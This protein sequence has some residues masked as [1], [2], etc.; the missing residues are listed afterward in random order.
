MIDSEGARPPADIQDCY[1]LAEMQRDLLSNGKPEQP[2][3]WNL[4]QVV[5]HLREDLD[6]VRLEEAWQH[7][8]NRHAIL[9]SCVHWETG[10]EP[11]LEV[12]S[13]VPVRIE[14]QDWRSLARVP[15]AL[16]LDAWLKADRRRSLPIDESPMM[17]IA[18]LRLG[19]ADYRLVW[20]FHHLLLDARS[21]TLVLNE[22]FTTYEALR[23]GRYPALGEAR[24]Y[25]EFIEWQRTQD[26]AAAKDFWRGFLQGFEGVTAVELPPPFPP[27]TLFR[28]A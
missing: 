26:S 20:T 10:R 1:P 2:V 28:P 21:F 22:V 27:P 18:L 25:R 4:E 7:V 24:R 16:A 13:I 6:A 19:E 11:I 15:R 23:Y 12:H 17:R 3:G 8:V 9:R 14:R 5:G